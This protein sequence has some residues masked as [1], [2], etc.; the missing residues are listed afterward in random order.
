MHARNLSNPGALAV[1]AALVAAAPSAAAAADTSPTGVRGLSAAWWQWALSIPAAAMGATFPIAA[2]WFVQHAEHASRDA[3]TLY[4]ANT[5]GAATIQACHVGAGGLPSAP[6][7]CD[8]I[9]GVFHRRLHVQPFSRP[10]AV[11]LRRT[12]R[13]ELGSSIVAVSSSWLSVRD[14]VSIVSPR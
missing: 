5:V 4:S 7:A 12:I 8:C 13:R 9:E 14:T 10:S 3:G 1:V 11:R 2:R 6:P